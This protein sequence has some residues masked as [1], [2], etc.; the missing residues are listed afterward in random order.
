MKRKPTTL[1]AASAITLSL[2]AGCSAADTITSQETSTVVEATTATGAPTGNT[3]VD[4][5]TVAATTQSNVEDHANPDDYVWETSEVVDVSL[6]SEITADGDGVLIEGNTVTITE[7]GTYHISGTLSDGQI[8]IEA[9]DEAVVRLILDNADITNTAG[10]AIA[11]MSAERAV[12]L[13]AD[14]T[15]NTLTDAAVYVLSL[16]HISEPTRRNQSSRMPSSA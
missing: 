7:A 1:V 12:V 16:I 6:G 13:L 10:A 5:E 3:T 8:A 11:V 9:G 4:S 15:E 14:G 2:L